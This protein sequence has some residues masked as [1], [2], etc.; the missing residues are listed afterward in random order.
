MGYEISAEGHVDHKGSITQIANCPIGID[1]DRIEKER[2]RPGVQ[3]KIEALRDLYKD[4]KII[5]GRD[6]LDPTKGVLP[7]VRDARQLSAMC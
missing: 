1:A 5:I 7:K 2:Q 6:K 4:K 3:P